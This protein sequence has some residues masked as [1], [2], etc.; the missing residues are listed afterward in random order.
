MTSETSDM[1]E[2]VVIISYTD[3]GQIERVYLESIENAIKI[4]L[5]HNLKEFSDLISS[6]EDEDII[7]KINDLIK[8]DQW[9]EAVNF[10]Q[11]QNLDEV[12]LNN[13]FKWYPI[14]KLD[15]EIN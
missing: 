7:N 1:N 6:D 11:D 10:W 14:D 8:N 5:A 4:C 12:E 3:D 13:P 9:D 15:K 2:Q